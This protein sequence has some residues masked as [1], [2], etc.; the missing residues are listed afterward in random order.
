[1]ERFFTADCHFGHEKLFNA[2]HISKEIRTIEEYDT[3]LIDNIN[4][5]VGQRDYL[6]ILGDF[7][8]GKPQKYRQRI[9][10][11][12]IDFIIGNHDRKEDTRRTFGQY[13][14]I[15]V[16]RGS[17]KIVL[18]HYPI[19]FWPSSHRGA[20]HLYGHVHDKMETLLDNLFPQ[21]RSQDVGVDTAK[22]LLGEY[23][24]FHYE[25]CV[26]PLLQR[27]GHHHPSG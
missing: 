24:P 11:K 13:H 19:A 2:L 1:M 26:V 7:T 4:K 8:L 15:R 5:T 22:R 6:A 10:C 16:L 12:N 17:P 18:C 14:D 21:R 27:E 3:M 23:R 20:V 25:E 9:K